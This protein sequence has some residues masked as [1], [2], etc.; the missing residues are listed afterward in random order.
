MA[1]DNRKA[2]FNYEIIE[3]LTAGMILDGWEVKSL[4]AGSASIKP[5]WVS[6][7]DDEVWL[8]NSSIA[9][10]KFCQLEQIRIKSR[11]LLLN[12]TEIKRLQS[13]MREKGFTLVP[14]KIFSDRGWMKCEIGLAR[15][16]KKHDKRQVLK[17]RDQS[18]DI[19]RSLKY[20]R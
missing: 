19:Q 4:R 8:E 15:G 18:R 10:W 3:T 20:L 16:R 14:L 2:H 11:K 17:D 9:P 1:I 13:K 12:R 6:I 7:R 5:A